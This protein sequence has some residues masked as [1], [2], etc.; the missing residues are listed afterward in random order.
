MAFIGVNATIKDGVHIAE[1]TVVGM[2]SVVTHD[3][4]CGELVMGNPARSKGV[5]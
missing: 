2:G 5:A 3:T 4:K 1:K